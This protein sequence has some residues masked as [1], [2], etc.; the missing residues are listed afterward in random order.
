MQVSESDQPDPTAADL[1]GSYPLSGD[2]L[3]YRALA[4]G[5]HRAAEMLYRISLEQRAYNARLCY[6]EAMAIAFGAMR[7]AIRSARAE[8][9]IAFSYAPLGDVLE[10]VRKPLSDNGFSP[11]W[12]SRQR[13]PEEGKP[14]MVEVTCILTHVRGHSEASTLVRPVVVPIGRS[15]TPILS[16]EQALGKVVTYL[17]R[18]TLLDVCGMASTDEDVET[19][20]GEQAEPEWN[21]IA[22][23]DAIRTAD[24]QRLQVIRREILDGGGPTVGHNLPARAREV[25]GKPYQARLRE[26]DADDEAAKKTAADGAGGED[27]P[28]A[29]EPAHHEQHHERA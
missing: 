3:V 8:G 29:T 2:G 19:P 16:P 22:A 14:E 28:P 5:D 4:D 15:G 25:L 1:A 24:R 21:P 9:V 13:L 11:R 27:A 17:E 18:R 10:A 12:T 6:Y 20:I 23:L 7:S 26:L